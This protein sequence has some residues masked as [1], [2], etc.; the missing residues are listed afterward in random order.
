M[1]STTSGEILTTLKARIEALTPAVK[2]SP[3]DRYQVVVGL[4]AAFAGNR[5]VL[6]TAQP[7][8]RIQGGRTCSDWETVVLVECWY[9]DHP[10][11][12]VNACNDSEQICN[13][14]YDWVASTEG[15]TLGLLRA[16]PD[17]ANIVGSDGELQVSRSVRFVYR[18]LS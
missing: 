7:G 4:R 8:R 11:A 18:G 1:A 13:E 12:Y 3:D 15:E 9:L 2:A 10:D 17:L 5:Q 16:E 14:S 6:L